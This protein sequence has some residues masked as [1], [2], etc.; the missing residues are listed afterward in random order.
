M[1][2]RIVIDNKRALLDVIFDGA[3]NIKEWYGSGRIA[4]KT[5]LLP[6]E[7][8][9]EIGKLIVTSSAT[10]GT[11]NFVGTGPLD[12]TSL[13]LREIEKRTGES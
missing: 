10:D 6:Q 1:R 8:D 7:Y 5:A 3:G 11:F 12:W 9:T 4:E 2:K 13:N